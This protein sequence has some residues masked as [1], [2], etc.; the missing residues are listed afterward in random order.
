MSVFGNVVDIGKLIL[1]SNSFVAILLVAFFI[2]KSV[3]ISLKILSD[4]SD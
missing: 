1:F 3:V 4:V 2:A